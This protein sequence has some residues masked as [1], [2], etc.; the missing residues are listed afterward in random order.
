MNSNEL[1]E[2]LED[3]YRKFHQPFF[4]EDDPIHIPHLFTKKEDIEIAGFLTATIAWGQ[5][6]SILKSAHRIIKL[7]DGAPYDFILNHLEKDRAK[8]FG[9]VHRTFNADDLIYFFAALQNIYHNKGGLEKIFLHPQAKSMKERLA[10]FRTIFFE[11]DHLQRT[12]KHIANPF[13]GSAAKRINMFL[14]WMVRPSD[15]GIDFGIWTK[16]KPKDL[17]IPLDVH[18]ST[19]ARKLKLLERKQNDWKAV[20]EL[21]N[22]LK[23]F[24]A[25]DPVKYDFAL[26]GMGVYGL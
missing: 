6:K 8:V 25:N 26:F 5:R 16:L 9:F 11:L 4:I 24:D 23:L 1:K 10:H 13:K 12:E 22:N 7:M 21:T 17:M 2:I 3:N 19:V 20:E 18:T 14:R 15:A